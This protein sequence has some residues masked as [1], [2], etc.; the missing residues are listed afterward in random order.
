MANL[1]TLLTA[2]ISA[3]HILHYHDIVDAYGHIS[4]RH[5]DNASHFIMS[6]NRAPALVASASDFV[7]YNVED[8][9]ATDSDAPR[10]YIERYIHSEMYKRFSDVECVIHAHAPDVLPYAISGVPLRPVFHMPGFLGTDVP[11]WDIED[12][13]NATDKHDLLVRNEHEG[14]SLAS[15]FVAPENQTAEPATSVPDKRVVLMRKHGFTAWGPSIELAVY[16]AYFTTINARVQTDSVLLRN[17]FN[18]VTGNGAN[19]DTWGNGT[20]LFTNELEPLTALQATDA[21]DSID[22][23]IERPWDL[24]VAEVEANPLTKTKARVWNGLVTSASLCRHRDPQRPAV[25]C[26]PHFPH[27]LDIQCMQWTFHLF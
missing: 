6:A 9:S 20:A 18:G 21:Q 11:V 7:T 17:A 10:G 15:T 24:W 4:V 2:L 25:P 1:T 19:A 16:R 13:Y 14:A 8:A 26:W 27:S 5:P 3:N 12:A 22:G 23:T